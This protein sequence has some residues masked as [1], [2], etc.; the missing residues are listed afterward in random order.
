[1]GCNQSLVRE[2]S[3]RGP[4]LLPSTRSRGLFVLEV[5]QAEHLPKMDAVGMTD[6]YAEVSMID[7]ITHI[8]I[9]TQKTLP[10]DWTLNPVLHSYLA[11]R[12]IPAEDDV[13]FIRLW[14]NDVL[15]D[16][17]IGTVSITFKDLRSRLG[18][19]IEIP[20]R[21]E[22]RSRSF[23]GRP[24]TLS[25]R[26]VKCETHVDPRTNNVALGRAVSMSPKNKM[27]LAPKSP[28]QELCWKD[29]FIIRHGE[30]KWN[31]ATKTG[32][33]VDLVH[34]YDH[35][36]TLR[37]IKEAQRLNLCWTELGDADTKACKVMGMDEKSAQHVKEFLSAG[38]IYCSPFTRA[39]QTAFIACEGHPVLH[40]KGMTLLRNIREV[41]NFG[42]FDSVGQCSGE[43]IV[44]RAKACLA[45]ELKD[46]GRA[47]ELCNVNV[48]VNDAV[49]H[50]W[51]RLEVKEDQEHVARRLREVFASLRFRTDADVIILCGHS[52]FFH[53][54]VKN[55]LSDDLRR[56]S[57][58]WAFTLENMKLANG[59]CMK[60]SFE[61]NDMNPMAPPVINNAELVFGSRM[62]DKKRHKSRASDNR[63][64]HTEENKKSSFRNNRSRTSWGSNRSAPIR[65]EHI[66]VNLK[67]SV[68]SL[69]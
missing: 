51:S 32:N 50:W 38:E 26:L 14:D 45:T 58:E 63:L 9:A 56:R 30:S 21:M 5:I 46:A 22:S 15:H 60:L 52:N 37:G 67:K 43:D 1:M 39:L 7:A 65:K 17:K 42:S 36:L 33:V 8:P 69:Q 66:E 19:P 34:Q 29:V 20:L 35:E 68:S 41:K 62:Q 6:A 31:E 54:M 24:P 53:Q 25:F 2:R 10:C 28:P 57:P 11:F 13:I 47:A 64:T 40:R 4:S 49:G 59:G 12:F 61:W 3:S 27:S 44:P 48:D 55:H 18:E 16:E 23:D